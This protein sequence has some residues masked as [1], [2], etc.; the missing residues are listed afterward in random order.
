MSSMSRVQSDD[1]SMKRSEVAANFLYQ[2]VHVE[3]LTGR[4]IWGDTQC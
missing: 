4:L 1:I 2:K 3:I